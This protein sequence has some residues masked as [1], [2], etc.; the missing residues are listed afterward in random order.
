MDK[1]KRDRHEQLVILPL[2]ERWRHGLQL[3]LQLP[4]QLRVQPKRERCELMIN[5][6][7][8]FQRVLDW[9]LAMCSSS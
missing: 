4:L 3:P 1:R 7:H 9:K 5:L 6:V 8:R 2:Q